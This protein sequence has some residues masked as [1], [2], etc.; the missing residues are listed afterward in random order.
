ML[1]T[2]NINTKFGI[3]WISTITTR[4]KRNVP[5]TFGF[6]IVVPGANIFEWLLLSKEGL[7]ST[8]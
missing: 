5:A 3:K 1:G 4:H 2:V 7:Q 6:Q 8:Q